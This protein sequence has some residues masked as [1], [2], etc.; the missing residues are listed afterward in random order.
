MARL[1]VDEMV[2]GGIFVCMAWVVYNLGGRWAPGKDIWADFICIIIFVAAML[3]AQYISGV[4]TISGH[5]QYR[6]IM[7][8]KC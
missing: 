3:V 4:V 8:A 2:L 7:W 1:K 6:R 5:H